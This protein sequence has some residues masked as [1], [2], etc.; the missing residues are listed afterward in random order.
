MLKTEQR[1]V[2]SSDQTHGKLSR[3]LLAMCLITT[4]PDLVMLQHQPQPEFGWCLPPFFHFSVSAANVVS[5]LFSP[6][7]CAPTP[8]H[9]P[10]PARSTPEADQGL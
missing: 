1:A 9:A 5:P 10:L 2:C 4:L 8:R 3:K 7:L 6:F